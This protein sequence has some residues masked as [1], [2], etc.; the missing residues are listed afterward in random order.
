MKRRIEMVKAAKKNLNVIHFGKVLHRE[1]KM[2]SYSDDVYETFAF[3][4]DPALS[5]RDLENRISM[6]IRKRFPPRHF[7]GCGF[8]AN[9]HG[10]VK[11]I[12]PSNG[13]FVVYFYH[14]I[15]D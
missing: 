11:R 8:S 3:E 9:L 13:E 2:N 7:G 10:S 4:N 5:D 14:G 1:T 15:G 6:A 12:S